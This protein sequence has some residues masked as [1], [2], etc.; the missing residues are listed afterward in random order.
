MYILLKL[1]KLKY[2]LILKKLSV[3]I[4]NQG[5]PIRSKS[6]LSQQLFM[7]HGMDG[8]DIPS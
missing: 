3:P 8:M 7:N 6:M 1:G 2:A 4:G 5:I